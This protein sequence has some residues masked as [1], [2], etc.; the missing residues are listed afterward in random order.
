MQKVE[1][2]QLLPPMA[3]TVNAKVSKCIFAKSRC[4]RGLLAI[5]AV[6]LAAATLLPSCMTK[7]HS[8]SDVCPFKQPDVSV[9][10]Y[11]STRPRL[12][13]ILNNTFVQQP[14]TILLPVAPH[15]LQ[16]ES[17]GEY[18]GW[19]Q[20]A[21]IKY[22]LDQFTVDGGV[23]ALT[24]R[25]SATAAKE[26]YD[27]V[28]YLPIQSERDV[29]FTGAYPSKE[30]LVKNFDVQDVF[31]VAD[32]PTHLATQKSHKTQ[33]LSTVLPETLFKS[34]PQ[35][36][37]DQLAEK[38]IEIE[39]SFEALQAFHTSRFVKTEQ[40]L[41]RL[42]FASQLAAW[43]HKRVGKYIA[44]A[45]SV[46]EIELM[47]EF[48]RLS[49]LC[50]G[51]LQ[52]YPPIVGAGPNSA[53]LH[54][55]TGTFRGL[56][57]APIDKDTFV[58]IDAAPEFVG[59]TSDLTRTYPRRKQWTREMREVYGIVERVQS[60][61]VHEH[62][63]LGADW[64]AINRLAAV[65]LTVELVNAGFIL[66]TAEE[67]IAAGVAN[68][69]FMPHG[70]GHPVGLEVHDPT[71][72][73]FFGSVDDA[74]FIPREEGMEEFFAWSKETRP[75]LYDAARATFKVPKGHVCTVEP[76][77]YFIPKLLEQVRKGPLA[78]FVNWAKL[79]AGNYVSLGGVRIE[80]VVL[81]DHAG[82]K[83]IVTRL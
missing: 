64:A 69:V 7:K 46:T 42:A 76:G 30:E 27:I 52:S 12:F 3:S 55:R 24:K 43:V 36:V 83:L 23:V 26:I 48:I 75:A 16:A 58:L 6:A 60:K 82:Q 50:G 5:A 73:S 21:N 25:A 45:D 15:I 72:A 56:A 80:D 57:H 10:I 65:D 8:L 68:A 2:E 77:V 39:Y 78:K 14:H 67:A 54:Y 19:K 53:V 31:S 47:T 17:D 22:I 18:S 74:A 1:T 13:S 4:I 63:Q 29:V 37:V 51:D 40:E 38:G 59:Y 33:I 32:L 20:A 28:V 81:F 61:F 35:S 41:V 49:A 44:R 70:L 71:P 62:Y 9:P 66:G 34:L 11:H 79:E